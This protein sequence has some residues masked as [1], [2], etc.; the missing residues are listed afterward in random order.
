MILDSFSP[1]ARQSQI[2]AFNSQQPGLESQ[3]KNLSQGINKYLERHTEVYE[4][5]L[6][7]LSELFI[8]V[9]NAVQADTVT[10]GPSTFTLNFHRFSSSSRQSRSFPIDQ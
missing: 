4:R 1:S 6:I 2:D 9:H 10:P 7:R 8:R 3:L 5:D